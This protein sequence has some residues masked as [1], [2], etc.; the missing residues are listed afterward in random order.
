MFRHFPGSKM[1][2][3]LMCRFGRHR[4]DK[5]RARKL[6]GIWT[7]Q[8]SGC[9]VAMIRGEHQWELK[10]RPEAKSEKTGASGS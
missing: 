6:A 9:G 3:P 10:F 7:S 1:I 2:Q 5:R 4:P 8:C